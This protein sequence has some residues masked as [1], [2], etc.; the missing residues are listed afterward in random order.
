M[1]HFHEKKTKLINKY[2]HCRDKVRLY[3]N[4]EEHP[5]P[6]DTRRDPWRRQ[7]NHTEVMTI[8]RCGEMLEIWLRRSGASRDRWL[9]ENSHGGNI[10]ST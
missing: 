3:R 10:C 8:M 7:V 4:A 9:S 2:K 5:W 1:K 6:T